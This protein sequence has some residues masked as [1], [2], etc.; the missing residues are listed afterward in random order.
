[1]AAAIELPHR[2]WNWLGS[3]AAGL[4]FDLR[5][6]LLSWR[7]LRGSGLEIGALHRP[8]WVSRATSVKYADRMTV[9]Q[10]RQHY[11]E[12][13]DYPLVS[14]DV[15]DDGESLQDQ[16][17]ASV[18]FIIANH[19][20]EHTQD[21]LGTLAAHLRVLRVGGVL[22]LA[23]PDRR[24]TFDRERKAT[25]LDH[26]IKDHDE[27]PGWSRHLHQEEWAC[28]VDK[29]PSGAVAE[30]VRTLEETDY[31]IHY[32]VWAPTE[33]RA[34]LDYARRHLP[35]EVETVVTNQY[36]FIVILRKQREA[37]GED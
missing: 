34:L 4:V 7:Y 3:T 15:V 5:R 21:P 8:L 20:I 30:H 16:P 17:D 13:A 1:M 18:D 22:Y 28:L 10:L 31:S 35:I 37:H 25:S 11:P 33:F 24:K 14:V 12:L 26:I 2:G 27:G 36:E 32:H 19:F 23:V 29:V 9:E 6:R